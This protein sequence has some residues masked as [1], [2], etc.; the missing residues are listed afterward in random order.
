M[1]SCV[2]QGQ[3]HLLPFLM[4]SSSNSISLKM[5]KVYRDTEK[6]LQIIPESLCIASVRVSYV[7]EP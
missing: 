2:G 3:Y 7:S 1:P 5:I 6:Y 4:L